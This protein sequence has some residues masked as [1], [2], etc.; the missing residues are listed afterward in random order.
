MSSAA[1]GPG[2]AVLI[3]GFGDTRVS[4]PRRPA[5]L[6]VLDGRGP[7]ALKPAS[8]GPARRRRPRYPRR[9]D[10]I[11]FALLAAP[12]FP[13]LRPSN[14]ANL[15]RAAGVVTL[16]GQDNGRGGQDEDETRL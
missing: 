5:H 6:R 2:R 16:A 12:P 7:V 15:Q 8:R 14:A 13:W 9:G 10:P 3:S 1:F 4:R 11:R